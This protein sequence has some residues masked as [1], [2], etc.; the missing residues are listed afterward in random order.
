M[1]G[2]ELANRHRGDAR[3]LAR[4][5]EGPDPRE[6]NGT[7]WFAGPSSIRPATKSGSASTGTL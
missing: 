5:P 7:L 2:G 3:G 1:N 4:R 6:S